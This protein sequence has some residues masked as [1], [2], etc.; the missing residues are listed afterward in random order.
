ML[1]HIM[2]TYETN[3]EA[4]A[5]TY[6]EKEGQDPA[7]FTVGNITGEYYFDPS[8]GSACSKMIVQAQDKGFTSC[9][10]VVYVK[11]NGEIKAYYGVVEDEVLLV[12]AYPGQNP[13]EVRACAESLWAL[14]SGPG[15]WYG[16]GWPPGMSYD[17]WAY[18]HY[19]SVP[20]PVP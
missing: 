13:E 15:P 20:V 7:K 6:F 1:S 12:R 19:V 8:V 4:V 2:S 5:K 17:E 14:E 16:G 18:S 10:P 3:K 9:V 11:L